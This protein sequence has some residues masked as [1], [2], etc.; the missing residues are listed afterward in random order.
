MT[1]PQPPAPEAMDVIAQ[2]DEEV[3]SVEFLLD[4]IETGL[5]KGISVFRDDNGPQMRGLRSYEKARPQILS[6]AARLRDAERERDEAVRHQ[7]LNG[8][9]WK[10]RA[11]AA[12]ARVRELEEALRLVEG[13]IVERHIEGDTSYQPALI[14]RRALL[15]AADKEKP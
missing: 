10:A 3:N 7:R 13:F 4:D 5:R 12:E 9:A 8:E 2:A 14:A 1:D 11:E 15:A 6:L